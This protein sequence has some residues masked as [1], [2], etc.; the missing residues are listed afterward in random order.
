[1][2]ERKRLLAASIYQKGSSQAAL[3]TPEDIDSLFAPLS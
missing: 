2:Q 1:M 3:W